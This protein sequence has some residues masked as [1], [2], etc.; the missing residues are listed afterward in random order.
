MWF[1]EEPSQFSVGQTAQSL[2]SSIAEKPH[3][4]LDDCLNLLLSCFRK[5]MSGLGHFGGVV[6][7]A[8]GEVGADLEAGGIDAGRQLELRGGGALAH[9]GGDQ[10]HQE[11]ALQVKGQVTIICGYSD[12]F[13]TGL[14][15]S[16]T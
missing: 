11:G 12:T 14:N 16:R 6:G 15:C 2:T 3:I 9:G 7:G 1:M 5:R 4:G 13:A 10:E 8:E